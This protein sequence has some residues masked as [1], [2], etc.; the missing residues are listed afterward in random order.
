MYDR[1]L[2]TDFEQ[3]VKHICVKQ[4]LYKMLHDLWLYLDW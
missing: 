4:I 2:V 1:M 3:R